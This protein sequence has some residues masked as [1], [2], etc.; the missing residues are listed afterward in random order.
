MFWKR[1]TI[2]A[3]GYDVFCVVVWANSVTVSSFI[4]FFLRPLLTS[5]SFNEQLILLHLASIIVLIF[6]F[7]NKALYRYSRHQN[8]TC[9]HQHTFIIN[10][11]F[12]VKVRRNVPGYMVLTSPR[13]PVRHMIVVYVDD[14]TVHCT[15]IH[16][17]KPHYSLVFKKSDNL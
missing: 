14:I 10:V 9:E 4:V 6:S 5:S 15:P 12:T 8:T 1:E 3:E 16:V 17:K 7:L 2:V 13:G 11:L